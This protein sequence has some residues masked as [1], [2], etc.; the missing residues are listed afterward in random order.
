MLLCW[1]KRCKLFERQSSV[2]PSDVVVDKN[3]EMSKE[4]EKSSKKYRE[5]LQDVRVQTKTWKKMY[6]KDK[7]KFHTLPAL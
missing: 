1:S 2:R 3:A 7:M 4:K 5:R 6:K